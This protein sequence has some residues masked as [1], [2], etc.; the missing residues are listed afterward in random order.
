MSILKTWQDL[1]DYSPEPVETPA[2]VLANDRTKVDKGWADPEKIDV[3]FLQERKTYENEGVIVFDDDQRPLNPAGPTGKRGRLLGKWGPNH[4]A[5]P[6]ILHKTK[7]GWRMLAIERKDTQT[8]AMPGGMVDEGESIAEALA[9]ELKE[10]TE[11]V[12]DMKRADII[13]QGIVANDPRNTDNAWMET[14]VAMLVLDDVEAEAL[15]PKAGDDARD[16]KW[17]LLSEQNLEQLYA[18]HA[19]FVRKALSTL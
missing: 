19:A 4:A 8:W 5:D 16:V 17:L 2:Y 9:R 6:L 18:N 15:T 13:Y 11:V 3:A 12:L 1:T 10:E 7:E 14:S